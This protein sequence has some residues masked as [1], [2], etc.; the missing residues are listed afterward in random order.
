MKISK[1]IS[2]F[3]NENGF[4]LELVYEN[5]IDE[6]LK[7]YEDRIAW[8]KQKQINQW[9]K[10]LEHHNKD[11][12]LQAIKRRE[13][14]AIYK[15]KE[16]VAC[17]EV[18]KESRFWKENVNDSYYIYKIVT[19]VGTKN[20]GKFIFDICEKLAIENKIRYLK[21]DCLARNIK[22][23]EIY[24]SHGFELVRTDTQDYYT[25]NLRRKDLK[26]A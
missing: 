19:K 22:L 14:F 6:I 23:N 3:C 11:E 12:F 26:K 17:F 5:D 16:I 21:I 4:E 2:R 15:N 7:L 20:L 9:Q 24:N 10:Y 8:F 25:F 18:S 13:L 1:S